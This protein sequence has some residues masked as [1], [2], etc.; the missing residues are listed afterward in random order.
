FE[1]AQEVLRTLGSHQKEIALRDGRWFML[2]I[3]PYRTLE[4]KIDGVVLTFT[5]ITSVKAM[6]AD[7]R[8]RLT[9]HEQEHHDG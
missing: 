6:E 4:N 1:D 7:L 9:E 5:E 8:Q 3:L 2:R